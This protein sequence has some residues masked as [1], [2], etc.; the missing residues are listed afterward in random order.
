VASW[1]GSSRCLNSNSDYG[2]ATAYAAQLVRVRTGLRGLGA[3]LQLR[4]EAFGPCGPIRYGRRGQ[5]AEVEDA[6]AAVATREDRR[7]VQHALGAHLRT[8]GSWWTECFY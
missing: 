2:I 6:A 7:E 4:P 1:A 3:A 5:M 8:P